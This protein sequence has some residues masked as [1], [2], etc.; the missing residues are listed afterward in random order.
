MRRGPTRPRRR[1]PRARRCGPA[2]RFRSAEAW[3]RHIQQPVG[4]A[5]HTHVQTGPVVSRALRGRRPRGLL[6]P[7]GRRW[8][9]RRFRCGVRLCS[10][11]RLFV[12]L[13]SI[14]TDSG[15]VRQLRVQARRG[16]LRRDWHVPTRARSRTE[17][18]RRCAGLP[19]RSR[20][21]FKLPY[22]SAVRDPLK[23]VSERIDEAQPRGPPK[24][25]Y[26]TLF[27]SMK[28][29]WSN[30]GS[31]TKPR[32]L[33]SF[34]MVLKVPLF[35]RRKTTPSH[36]RFWRRKGRRE[37]CAGRRMP[38]RLRSPQRSRGRPRPADSTSSSSLYGSSK[39]GAVR[40]LETAPDASMV[41]CCLRMAPLRCA[42]S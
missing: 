40:K 41:G 28:V 33:Q 35:A 29:G 19:H 14:A 4:T 37:T 26:K 2:V 10:R 12:R 3:R 21:R 30:G 20:M 25:R 15:S 42:S 7:A 23:A 6:R 38:S 39:R 1:V 16:L 8:I 11:P 24:G 32:P 17:L 13:L 27:F 9:L 22:L 34:W 18:R 36:S 31:N 5:S